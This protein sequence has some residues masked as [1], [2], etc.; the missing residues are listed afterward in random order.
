[1]RKPPCDQ[2]GVVIT[3]LDS[4]S[5]TAQGPGDYE[6][7]PRPGEGVH[8]DSWCWRRAAL[9]GGAPAQRSGLAS[10]ALLDL[11]DARVVPTLPALGER[12][13][14]HLQH[15][16][17]GPA[18]GRAAAGCARTREHTGLDQPGREGR[19]VAPVKGLG[20]EHPDRAPVA[21]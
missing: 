12:P 14:G 8:Y 1:M 9:A 17:E 18:A 6:G 20:R 2:L 15:P 10:L 13:I 16:L 21:G 11:E 5:V 7:C 4:K 19:S 3:Q